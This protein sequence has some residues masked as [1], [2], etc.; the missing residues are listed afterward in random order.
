VA[1]LS[2]LHSMDLPESPAPST[3]DWGEP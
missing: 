3:P 1:F 2:S